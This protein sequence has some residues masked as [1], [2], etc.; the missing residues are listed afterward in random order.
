MRTAER[1]EKWENMVQEEKEEKWDKMLQEEKEKKGEKVDSGLAA[2]DEK[3][4][5]IIT[6]FGISAEPDV[7]QSGETLVDE[8]ISRVAVM[9]QRV[10]S[11]KMEIRKLK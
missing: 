5:G 10:D 6:F 3:I 11:I 2:L 7:V 4:R 9:I 1:E 8:L